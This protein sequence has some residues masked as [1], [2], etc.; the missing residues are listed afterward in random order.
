MRQKLVRLVYGF[1]FSTSVV[2]S[3]AETGWIETARANSQTD[4]KLLQKCE[5]KGITKLNRTAKIKLKILL[6]SNSV[7][8]KACL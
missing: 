8:Q 1:T 4:N 7:T 3:L 5:N 2:S 6:V